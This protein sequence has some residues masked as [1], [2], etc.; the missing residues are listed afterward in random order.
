MSRW[1][2]TFLAGSL[3]LLTAFVGTAQ[4][5]SS[6]KLSTGDSLRLEVL[7]DPTLNRTLL[8]AP[9]GRVS[10]PLAGGIKA[11]GRSL[12]AVQ[13][14][15]AAK[16]ASNFAAT[17]TVYLALER[18]ADLRPSTGTTGSGVEIF[19]MGEANKPGKLEI[20]PGTTMLQAFAQMGGFSKFAAT[21]RIQLRR[22]D[23]TSTFDYKAIEAGTS[24]AGN[25]V[26]KDGDV[27]VIPQR[28]LFE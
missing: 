15:V 26:L 3:A 5:Q 21:K 18:R 16:L 19:I 11:S 17:P 9:D 27:I 1:I 10:V 8:I 7:E 12:E 25:A 14:E 23:Q 22:G 6:Y 28:K 2:A 13:A 4:A 20:A 24:T